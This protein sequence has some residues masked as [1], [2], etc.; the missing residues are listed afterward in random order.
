M[1]S[2]DQWWRHHDILALGSLLH[3]NLQSLKV[4]LQLLFGNYAKNCE[5]WIRQ[6]KTKSTRHDC[7]CAQMQS[8]FVKKIF[9]FCPLNLKFSLHK[10]SY[11]Q[12]SLLKKIIW[13]IPCSDSILW[14]KGAKM[15]KII[16]NHVMTSSWR[17][18]TFQKNLSISNNLPSFNM[19]A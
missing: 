8:C 18:F 14:L 12:S 13:I 2:R 17:H 4:S 9:N 6:I 19:I 10:S 11:D 7:I 1:T 16:K 5:Y 15:E 3:H